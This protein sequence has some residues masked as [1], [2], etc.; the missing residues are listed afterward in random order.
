MEQQAGFLGISG[1]AWRWIGVL[2]L[3]MVALAFC[4]MVLLAF[5]VDIGIDFR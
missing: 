1:T 4:A 3:V 5:G 2:A